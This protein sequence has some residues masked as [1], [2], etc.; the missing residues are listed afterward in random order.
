M[1]QY[2]ILPA[3]ILASPEWGETKQ[4]HATLGDAVEEA[5]LVSLDNGGE[6]VLVCLVVGRG[7]HAGWEYVGRRLSEDA[8]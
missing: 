8:E 5:R 1:I 2:V 4:T 7:S 3:H 6:V